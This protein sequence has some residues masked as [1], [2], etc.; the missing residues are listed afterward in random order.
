MNSSP[1]SAPKDTIS[2]RFSVLRYWGVACCIYIVGVG[3]AQAQTDASREGKFEVASIRRCSSDLAPGD[4]SGGNVGEPSPENL[5]L[6]CQTVIGLIRM[7]FVVFADGHMNPDARVPIQGGPGWIQSETYRVKAKAMAAQNQGTMR[8]PMMQALLEDRFKLKMHREAQKAP[9]FALTIAKGGP[10]LQKWTEGSCVPMDFTKFPPQEPPNMCLTRAS[11]NGPNVL[12]EAQGVTV[13]EFFHRFFGNGIDG[14]PVVD[15]TG[16]K[17]QFN[18]RLTYAPDS[19]NNAT[20][21][22][23][24]AGGPLLSGYFF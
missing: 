5:N 23:E 16:V 3:L 14:R 22:G 7:A 21:S 2:S 10:K 17:G 12:I 8:G 11:P 13:G 4:R 15:K 18:F 1:S 9:V 20:T 19:V 24:Q 6:N